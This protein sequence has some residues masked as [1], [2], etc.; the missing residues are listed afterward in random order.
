MINASRGGTVDTAALV[1]ALRNDKI[2]GAGLDVIEGEP[3]TLSPY[4]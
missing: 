1:D 3:G 2:A 4:R